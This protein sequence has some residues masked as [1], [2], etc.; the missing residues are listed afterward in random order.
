MAPLLT[1]LRVVGAIIGF[2]GLGL[3]LTTVVSVTDVSLSII[4]ISMG[5]FLAALHRIALAK[6]MT[7]VTLHLFAALLLFASAANLC[8]TKCGT[9]IAYE[10][11]LGIPTA[12]VGMVAHLLVGG[13]LFLGRLRG[14]G[15]LILTAEAGSAFL[16][17]ASAFFG[18]IMALH[19]SYCAACFT[20]HLAM[21]IQAALVVR[22][23]G[24]GML[25]TRWTGMVTGALLGAVALNATFHHAVKDQANTSEALVSYLRTNGIS[26]TADQPAVGRPVAPSGIITDRDRAADAVARTGSP[27]AGDPLSGFDVTKHEAEVERLAR[28][29][30]NPGSGSESASTP[31]SIRTPTGLPPGEPSASPQGLRPVSEINLIGDPQAPVELRMVVDPH[32]NACARELEEV[33]QISDLITARKVVV[34]LMPIFKKEHGE[35]PQ[36]AATIMLASGFIS[37]QAFAETVT[38]M[39]RNQQSIRTAKDA[40][41]FVPK[42]V[43]SAVLMSII[44]TRQTEISTV[45][46]DSKNT[47]ML[48]GITTTPAIWLHRRGNP[49]PVRSFANMTTAAVL[50]IA[51]DSVLA[52]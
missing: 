6:P 27:I 38:A 14:S 33:T 25:A 13:C 10:S 16:I 9:L 50:R 7:S 17:G 18:L 22:A 2:G 48:R 29:M 15:P 40:L 21:L 47:Q 11:I 43:D 20:A 19:S 49:E 30:R 24:N 37:Q 39:F 34:R 8:A 23:Y 45:L 32:C 46:T 51:I 52:P 12:I 31:P 36:A 5:M 35:G 44:S 28:A 4:A 26:V 1:R 42:S 41:S 3:A